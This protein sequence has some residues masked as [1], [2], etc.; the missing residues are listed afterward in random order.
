MNISKLNSILNSESFGG[1]I[2][3]H[4]LK[5]SR[6]CLNYNSVNEITK[7]IGRCLVVHLFFNLNEND[8]ESVN[9]NYEQF[10]ESKFL[11]VIKTA[12]K[13]EA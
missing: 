4:F 5:P 11:E 6:M 1:F 3:T 9:N 7:F 8:L 2:K 12:D 13:C 10:L